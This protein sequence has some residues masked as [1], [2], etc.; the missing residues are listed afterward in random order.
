MGSNFYT[1]T[2]AVQNLHL[3]V[4]FQCNANCIFKTPQSAIQLVKF[5][6]FPLHTAEKILR[7]NLYV[8]MS[9]RF[10]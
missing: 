2:A 9:N 8:T 5:N 4:I 3:Q 6:V 1:S 10:L 7:I